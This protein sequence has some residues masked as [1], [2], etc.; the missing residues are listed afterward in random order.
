MGWIKVGRRR[1]NQPATSAIGTICDLGTG[2]ITTFL[3]SPTQSFKLNFSHMS[4]GG[5]Y[6]R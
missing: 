5:L 1:A 4:V 6:F 3:F 2:D